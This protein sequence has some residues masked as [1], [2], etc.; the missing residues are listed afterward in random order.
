MLKLS[1]L[2]PINQLL[3]VDRRFLSFP[4]PSAIGITP[5]RGAGFAFAFLAGAGATELVRSQ[6]LLK[7]PH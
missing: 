3:S 6:P 1:G 7:Q 5:S 4:S 2:E